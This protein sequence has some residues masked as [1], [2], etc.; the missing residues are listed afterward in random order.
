MV[1]AH[2]MLFLLVYLGILILPYTKWRVGPSFPVKLSSAFKRFSCHNMPLT[3]KQPS[4]P[5]VGMIAEAI[6]VC[7][8]C[9]LPELVFVSPALSIS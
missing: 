3:R 7:F 2:A 5:A 4:Q 9:V 6:L 8:S 1:Q